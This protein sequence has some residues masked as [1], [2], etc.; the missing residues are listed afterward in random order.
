[1][2]MTPPSLMQ[3][4]SAIWIIYTTAIAGP[5]VPGDHTGAADTQLPRKYSCEEFLSVP[6]PLCHDELSYLLLQNAQGAYS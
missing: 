3:S 6:P 2:C 5:T 1:M 4:R